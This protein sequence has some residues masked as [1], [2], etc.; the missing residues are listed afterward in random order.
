MADVAIAII[1]CGLFRLPNLE[2]EKT[3]RGQGTERR[4]NPWVAVR[5]NQAF[6]FI[7]VS[8]GEKRSYSSSVPIFFKH[9][10]YILHKDKT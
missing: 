8:R 6:W 1:L 3:T 7:R 4:I 5:D 9:L 10:T 2:K